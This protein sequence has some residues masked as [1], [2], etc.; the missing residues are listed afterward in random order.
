MTA[1][2]LH[3]TPKR[4]LR[5]YILYGFSGGKAHSR[6]FRR[7]MAEQGMEPASNIFDAD[8]LIAHSAGSLMVPKTAQAKLTLLIGVPLNRHTVK[9]Y[10]RAHITNIKNFFQ[11]RQLLQGIRISLDS[12]YYLLTHPLQNFRRA[13][14][15][16]KHNVPLP[17]G[18][19][20]QVVWIMNQHDPWS[21]IPELEKYIDDRPYSFVSMRGSHDSIWTDPDMFVGIIRQYANGLLAQTRKR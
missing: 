21:K 11:S 20:G 17:D 14:I 5:Y 2:S 6:R 3:S 10:F 4:V 15:V 8:I 12:T 1:T 9:T 18:K 16:D 13:K 19:H 7:L